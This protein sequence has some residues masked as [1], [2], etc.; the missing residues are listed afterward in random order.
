MI[1]ALT[2]EDSYEIQLLEFQNYSVW[3]ELLSGSTLASKV[4]VK[5]LC[6]ICN[7]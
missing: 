4:K 1:R 6:K 3:S 5:D 2:T 7:L